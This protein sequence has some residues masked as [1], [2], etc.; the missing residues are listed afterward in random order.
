MNGDE[1]RDVRFRIIVNGYDAPPV[2]DL[3]RRIAVE[4]D[5]GRPVGPLIADGTFRQ[6]GRTFPRK[7][8]WAYDPEAVDW[9]LDQLRRQ[10]DRSALAEVG[11]DP[12]RNLP[13]GNYFTRRGPAELANATTRPSLLEHRKQARQDQQY[14][15]QECED[16][17]RDFG[18]QPG[19]RLRWVRAGVMCRELRTA[20]QQTIASLRTALPATVSAGGRTFA[21]KRFTR[22]SRPGTASSPKPS[23]IV[24]VAARMAT[25]ELLDEA[26]M[27]VLHASGRNYDHSAD[28]RITFADQRSL[29]FPVRGTNLTNAVMTAVDQAG[30]RIARYRNHDRRVEIIVHP[31]QHLTD[32][33]ALALVIS[34]PWLSSYFSVPSQGGG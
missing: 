25:R 18:Q 34:A 21:W 30:N 5:A 15:A 28:A 16:G 33:F 31:R 13:L 29:R 6:V 20:E 1:V 11:A 2:D 23:R 4:L 19:A 14:L 32:E 7:Q 27:P 3:L 17:W 12:W 22:P 10:D 9:F 8:P 26:G 24:R